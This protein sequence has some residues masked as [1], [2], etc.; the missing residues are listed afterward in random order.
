MP[1]TKRLRAGALLATSFGA[2]CRDLGYSRAV[3]L[4]LTAC[5]LGS[6]GLMRDLGSVA[7]TD[8]AV[9]DLDDLG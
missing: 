6:T 9:A 2:L 4:G 8:L 7:G 1:T 5:V 3:T